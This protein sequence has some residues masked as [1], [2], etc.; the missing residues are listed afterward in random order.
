[1]KS[2]IEAGPTAEII[3][4][5]PF[6]AM[7]GWAL[8]KNA[9]VNEFD[10]A[11]TADTSENGYGYQWEV[12]DLVF[13][14]L[15]P[16]P[17]DADVVAAIEK[18][19]NRVPLKQMSH[20]TDFIQNFTRICFRPVKKWFPFPVE[21]V[22]GVPL[23]VALVSP[24]GSRFRFALCKGANRITM[25]TATSNSQISEII[26][27]LPDQMS[28][29]PTEGHRAWY[30]ACRNIQSMCAKNPTV[31]YD[32]IMDILCDIKADFSYQYPLV[33]MEAVD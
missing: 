32:E 26:R 19:P 3:N 24:T 13:V 23:H 33:Q 12:C 11:V 20:R 8:S 4:V 18:S 14:D 31:F 10:I 30:D 17:S 15:P 28:S 7:F 16:S 25:G 29:K 6:Y 27:A 22:P 9:I 5:R 2:I 21:H 1:M